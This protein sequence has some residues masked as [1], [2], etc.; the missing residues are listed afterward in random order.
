[1]DSTSESKVPSCAERAVPLPSPGSVSTKYSAAEI[2]VELASAN[3][4]LV[5]RTKR[6]SKAVRKGCIKNLF[7]GG[8]GGFDGDGATSGYR[9]RAHP[10]QVRWVCWYF[11]HWEYNCARQTYRCHYGSHCG[12]CTGHRVGLHRCRGNRR[13]E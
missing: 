10:G 9:N 6:K 4:P 8:S 11:V 13:R 5:P 12:P 1:M 3:K 2:L 7:H